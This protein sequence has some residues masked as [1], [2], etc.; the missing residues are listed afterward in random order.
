MKTVTPTSRFD[1]RGR[2]AIMDFWGLSDWR[3]VQRKMRYGAPVIQEP[4]GT[5]AA[6]S[7]DLDAWSVGASAKKN[8]RLHDNP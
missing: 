1:L 2:Q 3:S 8:D 4:D 7:L 5:W 6:S